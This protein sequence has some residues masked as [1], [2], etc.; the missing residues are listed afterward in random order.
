MK[1]QRP[2]VIS[3]H[4]NDDRHA[5]TAATASEASLRALM[6]QVQSLQ[7]TT[8]DLQ[9]RVSASTAATAAKDEL[10]L[11][12]L[13]LLTQKLST[14][15]E[16]NKALVV[17][18]EDQIG[19]LSSGAKTKDTTLCHYIDR[20]LGIACDNPRQKASLFCEVCD[21]TAD[22]KDGRCRYRCSRGRCGNQAR[23]NLGYCGKHIPSSRPSCIPVNKA[24][25]KAITVHGR[26]CQGKPMSG[27]FFCKDHLK[28]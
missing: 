3:V 24:K 22:L 21:R 2:R 1:Y 18:Q 10:Y 7:V 20:A 9:S 19:V 14:I 16:S 5:R 6:A 11:Q 26:Q 17:R 8:Q 4:E 12:S 15:E 13:R 28:K 23:R 25:C 27:H